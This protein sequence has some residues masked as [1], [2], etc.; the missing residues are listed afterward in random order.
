MHVIYCC[1]IS[2]P[3]LLQ[4]VFDF[5]LSPLTALELAFRDFALIGIKHNRPSKNP[6]PDQQIAFCAHH[7]RLIGGDESRVARRA[8][9]LFASSRD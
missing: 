8:L 3:F 9:Q 6:I 4:G 5:G 2:R 7:L 1:L